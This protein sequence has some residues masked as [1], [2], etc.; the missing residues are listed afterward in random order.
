MPVYKDK[1]RNTYYCSLSYKNYLGEYR[2]KMKRGFQTEPEAKEW[3]LIFRQQNIGNFEISFESFCNMYLEHE[4][5]RVGNTTYYQKALKIKTH[6]LPFFANFSIG[7]IEPIHV[8]EWQNHILKQ[9]YSNFYVKNLHGQ[10][11]HI[12]N[13]AILMFKLPCNPCK[14]VKII[15][16]KRNKKYTIVTLDTLQSILNLI[17]DN[18]LE[19]ILTTFFLTGMRLGELLA[20]TPKD[21]NT[22]KSTISISKSLLSFDGSKTIKPP[23]TD[24]SFRILSIPHSLVNQLTKFSANKSKDD[25]IFSKS[26]TYL[27]KVIKKLCRTLGIPKFTIHDLRHSHASYLLQ[28]NVSIIE[29][30]DRLGHENVYT[31]L[32]TYAH[33]IPNHYGLMNETLERIS[34]LLLTQPE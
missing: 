15:S 26:K 3:E 5:L 31:T 30:S 32:K 2:R 9:D 11:S 17:E 25:F 10:L 14:N 6:I 29:V 1:L 23:K 24:K 21:I 13:L 27:H 22:D 18:E 7:A 8:I 34:R 4:R 16:N 20:L 33:I 28:S 12:M 19:L